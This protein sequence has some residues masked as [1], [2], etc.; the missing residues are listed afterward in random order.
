MQAYHG[1]ARRPR[2]ISYRGR[3]HLSPVI[4]AI[5]SRCRMATMGTGK[6][7]SSHEVASKYNPK[8]GR[9]RFYEALPF[10]FDCFWFSSTSVI[11]PSTIRS[12]YALSKEDLEKGP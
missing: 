2:Y 6:Q 7:E 8:A 10:L 5:T 12:S 3:G 1:I 11:D 4:C 9:E